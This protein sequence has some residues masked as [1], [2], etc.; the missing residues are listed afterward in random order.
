MCKKFQKHQKKHQKTIWFKV[1]PFQ[2]ISRWNPKNQQ[3]FS[4]KKYFIL[5]CGYDHFIEEVGR[6]IDRGNRSTIRTLLHGKIMEV[7]P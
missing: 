3:K 2:Y 7:Q 6:G 4:I 1:V 5:R